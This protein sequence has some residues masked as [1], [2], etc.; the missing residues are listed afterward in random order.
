MTGGGVRERRG[1]SRPWSQFASSAEA[2]EGRRVPAAPG[3][4]RALPHAAGVDRRV[5]RRSTRAG[6]TR[7]RHDWFLCHFSAHSLRQEMVGWQP[8]RRLMIAEES[9]F[10][11]LYEKGNVGAASMYLLIDDLLRSGTAGAGPAS[12][13]RGARKR[14]MYHGLRGMTVVEGD[15]K[16]RPD[17]CRLVGTTHRGL[18]QVWIDFESALVQRADH[19]PAA[20]GAASARGL[21]AAADQFAPAGGRGQPL[22]QPRGLQHRRR[23]MRNCG[24][25]FVA[26]RWPSIATSACS[27][28]IMPRRAASPS[29]CGART[30][31]SARKR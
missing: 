31:M 5:M 9:W 4:R 2:A 10:T 13:V 1:R 27:S 19:R 21:S 15:M 18:A 3:R 14:P 28:R 20:V 7:H 26:M 11:N 16:S 6:S 24:R 30:R 25:M 12:I 8:R 23:R 17:Q 29:G 22:D